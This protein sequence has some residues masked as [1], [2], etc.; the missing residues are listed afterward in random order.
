MKYT[1]ISVVKDGVKVTVCEYRKP[2]KT[3]KTWSS[4]VGHAFNYVGLPGRGKAK[5]N[6]TKTNRF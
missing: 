3:Q 6:S 1:D 5:G 2:R 4:E